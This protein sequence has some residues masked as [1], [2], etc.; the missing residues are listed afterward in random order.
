[1]TTIAVSK[2]L[3]PQV[4]RTIESSTRG[5]NFSEEDKNYIFWFMLTNGLFDFSGGRTDVGIMYFD[6]QFFENL[7]LARGYSTKAGVPSL[8]TAALFY[9]R[10]ADFLSERLCARV[11]RNEAL[12][13]FLQLT[14]NKI[15][16]VV[17]G[18]QVKCD[19]QKMGGFA[20]SCLHIK[21]CFPQA[22]IKNIFKL[23]V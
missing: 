18:Y 12:F 22:S 19:I 7:Y 20:K 21:Q 11:E 15:I 6:N 8:C 1:M 2:R 17:N 16:Y 4:W 5:L 10:L 9:E 3:F 23:A 13:L 14:R